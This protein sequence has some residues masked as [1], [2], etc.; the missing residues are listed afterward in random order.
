MTNMNVYVV[1]Q[2]VKQYDEGPVWEVAGIYFDKIKAEL[3]CLDESFFVGPVE[4]NTPLPLKKTIWPGAYYPNSR[5]L[6]QPTPPDK[7]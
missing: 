1:G 3:N 5:T 7:E 2:Y 6:K 4:M